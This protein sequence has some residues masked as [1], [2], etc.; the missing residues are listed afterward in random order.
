MFPAEQSDALLVSVLILYMYPIC[1]LFRAKFSAFLCVLMVTSLFK[2][3][4]MHSVEVLS[5]VLKH[6]EVVMCFL[7][8]YLCHII[9]FRH[10]IW[11]C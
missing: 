4:S 3:A 7:E 5:S 1:S 6:R 9:S 8:K 10:V 11:C 2:M